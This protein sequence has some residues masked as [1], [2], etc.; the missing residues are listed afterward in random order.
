MSFWND[1]TGF[2]HDV[3][4]LPD[5]TAKSLDVFS[6]QS[7]TPLFASVAVPVASMPEIHALDAQ[8]DRLNA[9]YEERPGAVE[10]R[11]KGG[12]GSHFMAAVVSQDRLGA[13]LTRMLDPNQFLSPHGIRSLS[14]HHE[15]NPYM[16]DVHGQTYS[17]SY[18]PAES[19]NRMFGGNSNWRGP[20]WIPMNFLLIQSINTY[21]RFFGDT[22]TVM[23]PAG[24]ENRLTLAQVADDLADR[25]CSLFVRGKDGTRPV[26][27]P[28]D[29][30]QSDPHWR[31]LIPFYE[32]FDGDDGH[33][34]GASHQTG[35]TASVALLLQYR[36]SLRFNG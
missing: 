17:V 33:G 34:V 16:Y 29:Y 4:E 28:N 2:Y 21:S 22:Y 12:D 23:D 25:L 11:L 18:W 7:L 32:Y 30:F 35:W 8:L 6:M 36:G 3:I 5:G 14:K 26:F 15:G 20:V 31:D 24:T 10:L 27:G 9:V 19:H 1:S 13:V